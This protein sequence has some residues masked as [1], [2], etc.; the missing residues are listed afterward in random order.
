M[1]SRNYSKFSSKDFQDDVSI[2]NWNYGLDNPTDLF[3][4]FFLEVRRLCG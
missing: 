2:Q 3:N 4:D 1:Y